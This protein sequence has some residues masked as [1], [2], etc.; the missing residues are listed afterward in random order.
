MS[1]RVENGRSKPTVYFEPQG[2]TEQFDS[3]VAAKWIFD[4]YPQLAKSMIC[5]I[6]CDHNGHQTSGG[7]L[8][9]GF[10]SG[11]CVTWAPDRDS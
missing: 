1:F 10:E 5:V 9:V 4:N 6:I 3:W 8:L 11:A 7:Q 2:E